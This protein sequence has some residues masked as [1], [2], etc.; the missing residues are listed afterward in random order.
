MS[1][2]THTQRIT[3]DDICAAIQ[4]MEDLRRYEELRTQEAIRNAV[5]VCNRENKWKLKQAIPELCVLG[6]DVCDD[7][8][9]MVTDKELAENIRRGIKD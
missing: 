5:I 8:I 4:K 3:L 7:K 2:P 9:Y 6:T 1:N